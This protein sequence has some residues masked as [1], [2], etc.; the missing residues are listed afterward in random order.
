M[1]QEAKN[2]LRLR[3]EAKVDLQSAKLK[4]EVQC[5]LLQNWIDYFETD[6]EAPLP[7]S[8]PSLQDL[9]EVIDE[10]NEARA[11]LAALKTTPG[12]SS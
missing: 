11:R 5:L 7:K 10:M 6:G 4:A 3:A 8:Y 12:A 1:T 2:L 9:M